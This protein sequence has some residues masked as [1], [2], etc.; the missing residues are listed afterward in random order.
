MFAEWTEDE[1]P[2]VRYSKRVAG[3]L[4]CNSDLRAL[5]WLVRHLGNQRLR[6]LSERAGEGRAPVSLSGTD[7][8]RGHP[9][10]GAAK[11]IVDAY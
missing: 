5:D 8:R 11:V 7:A 4:P 1:E 3:S 10:P 6:A 9:M 2:T